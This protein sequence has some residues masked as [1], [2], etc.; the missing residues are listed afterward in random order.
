MNVTYLASC[1]MHTFWLT[2]HYRTDS[3]VVTEGSRWYQQA[4][5]LE[6]APD[7]PSNPSTNYTSDTSTTITW[8][9]PG[10]RSCLHQYEV[11]Y[12][13]INSVSKQCFLVENATHT[14]E[15]LES[16]TVYHVTVTSVSPAGM[17]GGHVTFDTN[18]DDA[19]PGSPEHLTIADQTSTTVTLSWDDPLDR[20]R[21]IDS[22]LPIII[23]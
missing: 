19:A 21:C 11:C 4:T 9:P 20:A 1:S 18:T 23:F 12:T 2:P 15:G 14:A 7:A 17:R 3:G 13:R 6:T 8:S 22:I 5:T 16:C 10:D